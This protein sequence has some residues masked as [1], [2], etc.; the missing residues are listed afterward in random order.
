[1]LKNLAID[2]IKVRIMYKG[3]IVMWAAVIGNAEIG[4][5]LTNSHDDGEL[6]QRIAEAVFKERQNPTVEP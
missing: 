1:M 4:E 3:D 2:D 6:V 5:T